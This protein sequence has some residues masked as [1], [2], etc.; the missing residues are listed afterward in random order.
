MNY[1]NIVFKIQIKASITAINNTCPI[2]TPTLKNNR[3]E[4]KLSSGKPISVRTAEKPKPCNKPKMEDIKK[5][6]C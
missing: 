4:T 3:A 6:Y 2:S 5:G 1:L